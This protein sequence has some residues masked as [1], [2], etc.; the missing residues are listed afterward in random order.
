MQ[1]LFNIF[2][3]ARIKVQMLS[4]SA[5]NINISL[6]VATDRIDEIVPVIHKEFIG[7]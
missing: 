3:T 7:S 6:L 2:Q 5:S 1:K 4:Y